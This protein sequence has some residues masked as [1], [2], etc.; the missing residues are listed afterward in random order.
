MRLLPILF[1]ICYLLIYKLFD[2]M[3]N[4]YLTPINRNNLFYSEEDFDFETDIVMGYMEE[5][6]NQTVV[7]FEVDREKTTV[8]ATYKEVN[9]TVRYKAPKEIPCLFEIKDSEIKSYDSKSSNGVYAIGGALTVYVMPKILEKYKC[10]IKRGD[11]LGI[12]ID[13]NRM[14][15]YSVVDDGKVNTANTLYVGA[16]KTAYR[17][18]K[19][20]IVDENE[21]NGI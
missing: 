5:Y 19:G 3:P 17:I 9:G 16:Y 13:T 1:Y 12:Q 11:Y 7:V 10:D 2:S 6:T 8:N 21:F 20:A 15:Y 4:N 14:V 18:I